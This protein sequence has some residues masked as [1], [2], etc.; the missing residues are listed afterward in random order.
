MTTPRRTLVDQ[1]GPMFYHLVSRCVRRAWLCGRQG[2]HDF[3]HR[4]AWI[5]DRL[6][7]LCPSFSLEV[8]AYSIMSNHFHLVVYFDPTAAHSWT[9]EEVADR[10]L[11]ACPPKTVNGELDS[12]M[13]EFRRSAL[14]AD[15]EKI[16][17]LRHKL[18]SLSVFMQLLKQPIA[19]RANLEDG[20]QGHFFEKRFYSGALLD[21]EAV[22]A[23]MA[24]VD[25]NPIRAQL[26]DTLEQS[27][28]TSIARRI[29][30]GEFDLNLK[31]IMSGLRKQS[32]LLSLTLT[33]YMHRLMS[34]V[35]VVIDK[36]F[37]K[38]NDPIARW[39]QN[40]SLIHRPQRAFGL[41]SVLA[42]W[43]DQRKLQLRELPLS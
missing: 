24:Y 5:T 3:S 6:A 13:V 27:E 18:S 26:A 16:E 42:N 30:S 35:N 1:T 31:P 38:Q 33:D 39:Q 7:H 10:W 22:L 25:L 11:A 32:P 8:H 41:K 34:V 36:P 19:R 17:L 28:Q 40:V 20:C 9:A 37:E 12:G 4:K 23:A 2:R 43:I 15:P 21:E 14:I 29:R